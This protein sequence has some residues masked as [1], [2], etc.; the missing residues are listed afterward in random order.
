MK[1]LKNGFELMSNAHH[2]DLHLAEMAALKEKNQ[3]LSESMASQEFIL[4]LLLGALL[5]MGLIFIWNQLQEQN[6]K[7]K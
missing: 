1:I 3:Q 6:T 7:D 2:T 4:K 5:G